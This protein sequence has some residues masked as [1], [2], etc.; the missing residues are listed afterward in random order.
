MTTSKSLGLSVLTVALVVMVCFSVVSISGDSG[1]ADPTYVTNEEQ[2]RTALAVENAYV[3]MKN[4][5]TILDTSVFLEKPGV[6]LDGGRFTLTCNKGHNGVLLGI[7]ADN[8]TLKNVILDCYNA[9]EGISVYKA[10]NVTFTLVEIDRSKTNA[11]TVD[12]SEVKITTKLVLSGNGDKPNDYVY[13]GDYIELKWTDSTFN[14]KCSVTFADDHPLYTFD[15]LN[16]TI[17]SSDLAN[18]G[19]TTENWNTKF[20]VKHGNYEFPCS[21]YGTVGNEIILINNGIAKVGNE[22]FATLRDAALKAMNLGIKVELTQECMGGGFE[23]PDGH[24]SLQIDL[25][26][27]TYVLMDPDGVPSCNDNNFKFGKGGEVSIVNGTIDPVNTEL[28]IVI[29]TKC[30]TVL[31]DLIIIGYHIIHGGQPFSTDIYAL[32]V[33]GTTCKFDNVN[34]DCKSKVNENRSYALDNG[35]TLIITNGHTIVCGDSI[36]KG[37]SQIVV[38]SYFEEL[39]GVMGR[40]SNIIMSDGSFISI[41]VGG[42]LSASVIGDSSGNVIQT[43][44]IGVLADSVITSEKIVNAKT[45]PMSVSGIFY[46]SEDPGA[47]FFIENHTVGDDSPVMVNLIVGEK[48]TLTLNTKITVSGN[49]VME[50]GS[51]LIVLDGCSFVS[52]NGS[53]LILADGTKVNDEIVQGNHIYKFN[54]DGT[55]AEQTIAVFSIDSRVKSYS[56]DG[57]VV[58]YI[59]ASKTD[60]PLKIDLSKI[61]LE[62]DG[63]YKLSGWIVNDVLYGTYG[64]VSVT[65]NC[66]ITPVLTYDYGTS[67]SSDNNA[68]IIIIVAVITGLVM[69]LIA[70]SRD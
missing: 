26:G 24:K 16:L 4:D 39:W 42:M 45:I 57:V 5:I 18:A 35:A 30:D 17:S 59:E 15:R 37:G 58:D 53:H 68:L 48:V 23:L 22:R 27:Y 14:D 41:K 8:C 19:V 64:E 38:E 7:K 12:M 3:V 20:I 21:V 28:F 25:N 40:S 49:L 36:V 11:L 54:D 1:D 46:S 60:G 6:T 63:P 66:V 47:E 33:D 43:Q 44:D 51:E 61:S 13:M 9:A 2:L 50:S 31:K 55:I 65:E 62:I 52:S 10:K 29:E 32:S 67:G 34:L 56:Y 70:Y 69:S